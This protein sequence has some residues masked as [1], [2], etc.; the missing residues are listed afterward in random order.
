MY[1]K[2]SFLSVVVGMDDIK[3]CQEAIPAII[4]ARSGKL[5]AYGYKEINQDDRPRRCREVFIGDA[6]PLPFDISRENLKWDEQHGKF[7][8]KPRN[9]CYPAVFD[10][11]TLK[12]LAYGVNEVNLFE[13]GAEGN[14]LDNTM[15][16]SD[17][18]YLPCRAARKDIM[19]NP[20]LRKMVA[21]TP[22]LQLRVVSNENELY[23]LKTLTPGVMVLMK[24]SCLVSGKDKEKAGHVFLCISDGTAWNLFEPLG[25]INFRLTTS[26]PPSS[27]VVDAPRGVDPDLAAS[28][29]ST[30]E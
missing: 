15:V 19:W 24:Q 16:V 3:T 17:A 11:E 14:T 12:L 10:K 21:T 25:S 4:E 18:G 29:T 26:P 1:S 20:E 9:E 23:Q 8:A 7:V 5:L 30:Q 2:S 28:D 22:L 6:G 27:P 13:A